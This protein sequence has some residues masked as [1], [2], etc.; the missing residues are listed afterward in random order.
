M[1][2][3]SYLKL[4]FEKYKIPVSESQMI[5]FDEFIS[6]PEVKILTDIITKSQDEIM[7]K[8]QLLN[9][10]DDI[11]TQHIPIPNGTVGKEYYKQLDF[12]AL[13]LM[14]LEEI[15]M[16]GVEEIGLEFDVD[17][18]TIKGMPT[19]SGNLKLQFLFKIKGEEASD[20]HKK[21]MLLVINPDPKSLWKNI[22]SDE[23]D[24]FWKPDNVVT[25]EKFG[26][27]HIVVASKRG[28]SH[29]NVGSFRDDDFAFKHFEDTGW[30]VVAVSDGAGSYPFSRKGSEI[31]CNAVIEYFGSSE[32]VDFLFKINED[33]KIFEQSKD[34]AFL[35][36]IKTTAIKNMYRSTVYVYDK[37]KDFAKATYEKYPE[38]FNISKIKNYLG[39]FHATLIFSLYK[40]YDFGYVF[41]TFGVGDC[42]IAV[43][44]KE[45]ESVYLLNTLD[46]GAFGGGTRFI[47]QSDIFQNPQ[48]MVKR[49]NFDIFPDFSY[50]FLMTDGIYDPK[51]EVEANLEKIEK[52]QEFI[53]DL[54]GKNTDNKKVDLSSTNESIG[55]EL[56]EWMNFWSSGNHDDRTLAI[57]F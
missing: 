10:I 45:Q 4:L 13:N 5:K 54:N 46:V 29:A 30:S 26:D 41:L 27:R 37:L 22:P 39:N 2:E 12:G 11:K 23:D 1:M 35:K 56:G 52:W 42:P 51:F 49:F 6:S 43:V 32:S 8:W 28:R 15:K 19:K 17:E 31:A 47:T 36:D 24:K 21:E 38:E 18:M 48:K 34:G 7:D 50:L 57:V 16:E 25:S 14:D 20:F 3:K 33:L 40:K 53:Q 44:G 55:E 9:R